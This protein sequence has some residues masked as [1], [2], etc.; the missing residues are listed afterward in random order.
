MAP[1]RLHCSGLTG[2]V[3]SSATATKSRTAKKR[4]EDQGGMLR[5][6]SHGK[7][8]ECKLPMRTRHSHRTRTHRRKDAHT[9]TR[10]HAH[11]HAKDP[12]K[13]EDDA[14]PAASST[15]IR[16]IPVH[17][18]DTYAHVQTQRAPHTPSHHPLQPQPASRLRKAYSSWV[19]SQCKTAV[20]LQADAPLPT[21]LRLDKTTFQRG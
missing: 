1:M 21:R 16:H 20:H 5:L 11:T 13:C 17:V 18:V 14:Q 15:K 2:L 12:H 10:T 3:G 8:W 19:A 7:T 6:A 4:G 9:H